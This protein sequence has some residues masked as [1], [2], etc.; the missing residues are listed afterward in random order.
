MDKTINRLFQI[1]RESDE[2]AVRLSEE[3]KKLKAKYDER[4]AEYLSSTRQ[5]LNA[6]LDEMKHDFEVERQHR[7]AAINQ[8]YK[9]NVNSIERIVDEDEYRFVDQFLEGLMKLGVARDE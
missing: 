5:Q 2:V 1:E 7:E 6:K 8:K 4:K 9:E 3:K